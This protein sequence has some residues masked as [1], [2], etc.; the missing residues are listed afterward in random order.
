ML[1]A[2]TNS[3]NRTGRASNQGGDALGA[4]DL[5]PEGG[6]G[7]FPSSLVPRHTPPKTSA[8]HASQP[9][10]PSLLQLHTLLEEDAHVGLTT[11]LDCFPTAWRQ[12][13]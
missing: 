4:S 2:C 1:M 5:T 9:P 12:L 6:S 11:V 10:P 8:A 7:H 13:L 3:G